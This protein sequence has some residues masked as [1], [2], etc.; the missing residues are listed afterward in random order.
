MA[1]SLM[2]KGLLGATLGAGALYMTFGT[3]AP[4]YVRTA[5]H[6]VRDTAR[7]QVSPQFEIDRARDEISSL[8]PAIHGNI[9]NLAR[10]QVDVEH[11]DREIVAIKA[12]LGSE[13]KVLTA[14][15]SSLDSGDFKLAGNVTYTA[16]EVKGELK[17][18]FDHYKQVNEL[19]KAKEETLKAKHKSVVAARQQL[20]QMDATKKALLTKLAGIEARLKMIETTKES[21]EFNFDDSALARAKAAVSEL[22][23]RLDVM[24]RQAELEGTFS[25][26]SIPVVVDP[27]RDVLREMDAEFGPPAAKPSA[28][29]DKSL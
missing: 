23:K 16:D 29:E 19:L 24:A 25:N 28:G 8:E 2:K 6:R 14:L 18:R 20:A 21:N 15:R 22:E 13:K 3:S 11:L 27:S 4:S 10:A 26:G 9:E 1:C 12:N 7:H 5:F 17:Q